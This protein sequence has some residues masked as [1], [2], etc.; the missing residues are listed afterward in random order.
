M[1]KKRV[2][3]IIIGIV[4]VLFLLMMIDYLMV[5]ENLNQNKSI[6]ERGE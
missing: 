2:W 4:T 5:H 3:T 1:N 6:I